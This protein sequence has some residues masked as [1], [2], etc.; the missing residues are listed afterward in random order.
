MQAEDMLLEVQRRR[1]ASASETAPPADGG[2]G[3]DAEASSSNRLARGA[4]GLESEA[5]TTHIADHLQAEAITAQEPPRAQPGALQPALSARRSF[6][7]GLWWPGAAGADGTDPGAASAADP[8]ARLS[9]SS[10]GADD[11]S[12]SGD[13]ATE[14]DTGSDSGGDSDSGSDSNS[15]SRSSGSEDGEAAAGGT[16]HGGEGEAQSALALELV[17][18]S[19][20]NIDVIEPHNLTLQVRL[21]LASACEPAASVVAYRAC[22]QGARLPHTQCVAKDFEAQQFIVSHRVLHHGYHHGYLH[23]PN[24]LAACAQVTCQRCRRPGEVVLPAGEGGGRSRR[25]DV[26]SSCAHCHHD[27]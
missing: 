9:H 16:F 19:V 23:A 7:Q 12:R 3:P 10:S 5:S 1:G 14:F 27:W 26:A 18:L 4:E 15:D 25:V 24:Q 22:S 6:G 8:A 13:A 2:P 17:D 21:T 11:S 20:D